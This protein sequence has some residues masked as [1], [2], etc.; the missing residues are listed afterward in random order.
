MPKLVHSSLLPENAE[1][2]GVFKERHE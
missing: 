1:L 2:V